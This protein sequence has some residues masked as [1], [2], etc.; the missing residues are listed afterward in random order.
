MKAK[1]M[2][3]TK[4]CKICQCAFTYKSE[5]KLQEGDKNGH[6]CNACKKQKKC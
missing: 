1:T 3:M 6:I 4:V 5:E 2:R